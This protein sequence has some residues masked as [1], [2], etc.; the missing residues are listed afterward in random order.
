M[1]FCLEGSENA[2][3]Q[4]LE[5]TLKENGLDVQLTK[6]SDKRERP[7]TKNKKEG[8]KKEEN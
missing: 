8:R 3:D 7:H 1:S 4:E 2:L 5:Q 6:P